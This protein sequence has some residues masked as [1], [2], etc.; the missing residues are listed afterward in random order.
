MRSAL[1]QNKYIVWVKKA[2]KKKNRFQSKNNWM[3]RLFDWLIAVM[4]SVSTFFCQVH[5]VFCVL[6]IWVC[7]WWYRWSLI[8]LLIAMCKCGKFV[9]FDFEK[10][11]EERRCW[12]AVFRLVFFSKFLCIITIDENVRHQL[13]VWW[14]A[15]ITIFFGC[16][17]RVQQNV[18]G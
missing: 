18:F 10:R 9:S 15:K 13:I 12:A 7:L 16:H 11:V 14:L 2:R 1:E 17:P 5:S 6:W 3:N 4:D 8:E